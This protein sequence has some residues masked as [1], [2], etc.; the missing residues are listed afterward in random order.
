M[1]SNI[2]SYN[3]R[4]ADM[5]LETS[6]KESNTDIAPDRE[7]PEDSGTGRRRAKR[8]LREILNIKKMK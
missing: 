1:D 8:D 2:A 6:F 3:K 5:I 4:L 7:S